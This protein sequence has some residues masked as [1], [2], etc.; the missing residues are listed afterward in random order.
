VI[1]P[2]PDEP[3]PL[4]RRNRA[5]G[6][7]I[8]GP[9]PLLPGFG[10]PRQHFASEQP[11]KEAGRAFRFVKIQLPQKDEQVT[12]AKFTFHIDKA[13]L[14]AAEQRDGHYLLRSNLTDED[15]AVC[16]PVTRN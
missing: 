8:P 1:E 14:K 6:A 13:K 7:E 12:R 11:K 9:L 5:C 16:G 4:A 15:P 2:H 3:V 10:P